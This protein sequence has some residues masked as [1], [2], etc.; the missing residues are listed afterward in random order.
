MDLA[1][2]TT[3]GTAQRRQRRPCPEV[4]V[5][6]LNIRQAVQYTGQSDKTIRAATERDPLTNRPKLDHARLTSKGI[7]S[8]TREMLDE[9][10]S[11]HVIRAAGHQPNTTKG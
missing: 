5:R 2:T 8:F 7:L 10:M 11:R 1:E 4:E 9:W 6:W 3:T